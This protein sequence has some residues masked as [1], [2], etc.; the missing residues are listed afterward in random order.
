MTNLLMLWGG[1]KTVFSL[2]NLV[3]V[4]IGSLV[5]IIVGAIPGIGS[6]SACALLLPITYSF[7]PT[8]AILLLASLYYSTMFGGCYS[9]ILLNIPGD[10]PAVMTALDGY[11][12]ARRGKAGKALMTANFSSFFGGLIGMLILTF[13]VAWLARVGLNFGNAEMTTLLLVALMSISWLIGDDPVKGLVSTLIGALIACL[14]MDP[15]YGTARLN[16]GNISLLGGIKFPA[17]VIGAVGFSQVIHLVTV[18]NSYSVNYEDLT[19]K[20]SLL[21]G[22]EL[23]RILPVAA[24]SGVLGT[25]IGVLPGAGAT[26]AAFLNYA[27]QKKNFKDVPVPYGEG[28]IEGISACEAA[29]NSAAAGAFAPLL[30]LGIPGSGTGTVLLGGLLMWG[31]QPGPLLFTNN[32]DF[33]WACIASLF[34]ANVIS[35]FCGTVLMPLMSRVITI[36]NRILVPVIASI[37][38]AGSFAATE[39]MFGVITMFVAGIVC[40]VIDKHGYPLAPLLL[41][42][43]LVPLFEKYMR[44]AFATTA[45]NPS[46]F[47]ASAICKV[48]LLVFVFLLVAPVIKKFIQKKKQTK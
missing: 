11:P 4:I 31:L 42:F 16:F 18:K 43:V 7:S 35:L 21:T 41:A 12:L 29:N 5:G 19:F 33:A 32:P 15:L 13:S 28:A 24:R 44:R 30:A 23:K 8:S 37:C 36:P 14:G 45:G 9:A 6:L 2:S 47:W 22:A 17:L 27:I 26:T 3:I 48:C 1:L 38:I 10:S 46:I 25:F 34:L 40:Y 39:S 20:K